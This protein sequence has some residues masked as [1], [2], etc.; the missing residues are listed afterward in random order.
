LDGCA[1]GSI[2]VK[3]ISG[4]VGKTAAV[5]FNI[6]EAEIVDRLK[7]LIREHGKWFDPAPRGAPL[8]PFPYAYSGNCCSE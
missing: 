8:K 3:Q 6:P 5:K 2:S 7:D 4:I 1:S